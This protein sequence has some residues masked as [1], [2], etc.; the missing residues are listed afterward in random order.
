ML[1]Y[2]FSHISIWHLFS[3][4]LGLY[5]IG[6]S[7]EGIFGPRV[8]LMLYLS[9]GLLGG[10]VSL[11]GS[12]KFDTRPTIGA[13]ASVSALLSFFIMNFPKEKMYFFPIPFGISAWII[14]VCYYFYTLRHV[15]DFNSNVQHKGHLTGFLTGVAYYFI[16][17]G[18]VF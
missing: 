7:I 6:R 14:G 9:G 2:S 1:S 12:N 11:L 15:N 5:Y 3:N 10:I 13:S 16:F 8:L 18:I 17:H 4:C